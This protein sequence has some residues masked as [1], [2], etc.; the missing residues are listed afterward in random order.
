MPIVA[1][2][3]VWAY[4]HVKNVWIWVFFLLVFF[5]LW[6]RA[7]Y[8]ILTNFAI[9][10]IADSD[11]S[12]YMNDWPAGG[13]IKETIAYLANQAK[14]KKIFVA[15]EGT[16]GSLPTYAVQIYLGDNKNVSEEGIWP[17][18]SQIPQDLLQKAKTMDTYMIF[19]QQATP[20][21]WPLQLI[22]KYRKGI[23][24]VYLRLYK[25]KPL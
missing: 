2:F 14:T 3:V 17:V 21:A 20:P 11:L 7:D 18:P 6:A 5:T 19:Y 12:Q 9:A 15:S 8:Y 22:A 4:T 13:G 24:H 1:L 25:V 16:F 10:P 23:G